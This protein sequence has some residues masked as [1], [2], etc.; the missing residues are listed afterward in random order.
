MACRYNA[1]FHIAP[2]PSG[3]LAVF[4]DGWQLVAVA[5][6]EELV[7]YFRNPPALRQRPAP[8]ESAS[9]FLSSLGL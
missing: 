5:T 9:D 8:A 6:P 7:E 4:F 1:S 3:K 2:L